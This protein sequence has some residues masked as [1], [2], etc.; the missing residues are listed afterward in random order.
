MQIIIPKYF[1]RM[2]LMKISK[3]NKNNTAFE[4]CKWCLEN[5]L[6]KKNNYYD[7]NLKLNWKSMKNNERT[8][9]HIWGRLWL[10]GNRWKKMDTKSCVQIL[11]EREYT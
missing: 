5:C 8:R 10:S 11:D 7:V 4:K 2:H 3:Q 9:T 1:F 6:D